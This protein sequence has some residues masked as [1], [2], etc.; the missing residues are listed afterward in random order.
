MYIMNHNINIR[1]KQLVRNKNPELSY[2]TFPLM[3]FKGENG[4]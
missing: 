2:N 3:K 4:V 1:P